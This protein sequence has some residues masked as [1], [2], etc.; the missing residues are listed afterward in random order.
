MTSTV[1]SDEQ[2]PSAKSPPHK[3]SRTEVSNETEVQQG[4]QETIPILQAD[5]DLQQAPPMPHTY[6]E[7]KAM[8]EDMDTETTT[9]M[10]ISI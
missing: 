7:L 8:Q 2:I 1:E 5:I 10:T 6:E 3:K 4:A 9:L